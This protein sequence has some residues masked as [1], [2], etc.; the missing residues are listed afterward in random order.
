MQLPIHVGDDSLGI[1]HF[2]HVFGHDGRGK[3]S[4]VVYFKWKRSCG[5]S[6][7]TKNSLKRTWWDLNLPVPERARLGIVRARAIFDTEVMLGENDLLINI[8]IIN[9]SLPQWMLRVECR[10]KA[11]VS[12][13]TRNTCSSIM[14]FM[15]D[16]A[17][18]WL[19]NVTWQQILHSTSS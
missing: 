13:G 4:R 16:V 9:I 18:T 7:Q 19:L 3:A 14:L 10:G 5:V 6:I 1:S 8:G 15:R 11:F 2:L 12:N 17:V